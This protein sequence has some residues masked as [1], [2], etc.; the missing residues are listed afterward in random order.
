M[1][2]EERARYNVEYK[3]SSKGRAAIAQ[4]QARYLASPRGKAASR[5]H[6]V[7]PRGRARQRRYNSSVKG[8]AR[9]ERQRVRG[10]GQ[11]L[12]ARKEIISDDVI[13]LCETLGVELDSLT[14]EDK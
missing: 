4:A 7:S 12:L 3:A 9:Q 10:L 2:K 1:N 6:D 14:L 13:A 5:K 8:K 11:P